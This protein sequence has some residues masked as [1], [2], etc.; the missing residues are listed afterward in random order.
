MNNNT[1]RQMDSQN[2]EMEEKTIDIIEI[3]KAIWNNRKLLLLCMGI[4]LIAGL[5][6]AF[7]TPNLYTASTI[8]VPQMGKGSSSSSLSSLAS[9]AGFDL[10]SMSQASADISPLI[11]PQILNSIPFKLELMNTRVHFAKVDTAVSV[12]DY[13]VKCKKQT[14]VEKLKQYTIGLPGVIINAIKGKEKLP[15]NTNRNRINLPITITSTQLAIKKMLDQ[16]V[17]LNVEKKEGYLTLTTTME[18]PIVAAELTLKA[19]K[20]LQEFIINFKVEKSQAELQFIQERFD[21]A[22]A[23]AEGYNY[24]VAANADRFKN[25]VSNLP[26][27]SNDRLQIKYNIANSVY[28]ELAKQLE[29]AKIQ[30]KKDTPTFTIIEPV[31]VP[32]N[33]D[34]GSRSKKVIAFIVFG[35]VIGLFIIYLKYFI[36]NIK[37]KW[38]DNKQN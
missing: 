18:E 6:M 23:Q 36:V 16:Q 33:K 4:G 34:N 25:L 27:V 1:Q 26:Q 15:E 22:K 32:I 3:A 17:Q 9:L 14:I 7:T 13:Y 19:Q 37:V 21:I 2:F 11:Y 38:I 5:G 10:G 29:Q 30:V 20:M 12:Y 8:M 28:L 35:G 31:S 24:N